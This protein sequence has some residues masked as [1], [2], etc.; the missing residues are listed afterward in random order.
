MTDDHI[1]QPVALGMLHQLID[2][3]WLIGVEV[4]GTTDC[5][6]HGQM[7]GDEGCISTGFGLC[8]VFSRHSPAG[9]DCNR[10]ARFLFRPHDA[11]MTE[12]IAEKRVM[13]GE[14]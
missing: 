3:G 2:S 10:A 8:D 6:E 12:A 11:L 13:E 1:P 4:F 5:C 14:L 7:Q 9:S